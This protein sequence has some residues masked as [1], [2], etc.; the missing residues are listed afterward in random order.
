[1][2]SNVSILSDALKELDEDRDKESS[3]SSEDEEDELFMWVDDIKKC[4]N[5]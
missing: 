5:I 4:L 3:F 2:F 1:M